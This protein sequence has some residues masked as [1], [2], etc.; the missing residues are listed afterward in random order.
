M[1]TKKIK[2]AISDVKIVHSLI[3]HTHYSCPGVWNHHL[4][5]HTSTLRPSLG[6]WR[7]HIWRSLICQSSCS[8][9]FIQKCGKLHE[10][11]GNSRLGR[12]GFAIRRSFSTWIST[13][14]R[15]KD[16]VSR[17]NSKPNTK[18]QEV[19]RD[20]KKLALVEVQN[21]WINSPLYIVFLLSG[22]IFL[23]Q[24]NK[25]LALKHSYHTS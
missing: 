12:S 20:R 22:I 25:I 24:K 19:G 5:L 3:F 6:L 18:T 11:T 21:I 23:E 2:V 1:D 13:P 8:E 17:A 9:V 4:S 7:A 10:R 14:F 15:Q 16:Q